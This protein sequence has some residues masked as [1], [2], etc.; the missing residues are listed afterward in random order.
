MT[1]KKKKQKILAEEESSTT[2]DKNSQ[3]AGILAKISESTKK[4]VDE[5]EKE[6][7]T[8]QKKLQLQYGQGLS[9]DSFAKLF[10]K[11]NNV[12][13]AS[14]I[15]TKGPITSCREFNEFMEGNPEDKDTR[16]TLRGFLIL[17]GIFPFLICL[18][19]Y[20][21]KEINFLL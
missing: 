2:I 18:K 6:F 8:F 16:F 1:L 3:V 11:K 21:E 14:Q 15:S 19:I 4:S 9:V 17:K 13:L 12:K 7:N 10:A 5:I 20:Y